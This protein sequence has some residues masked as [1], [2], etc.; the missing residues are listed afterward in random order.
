MSKARLRGKRTRITSRKGVFNP[1]DET[2]VKHTKLGI[3]DLYEEKE[4]EL[5]NIPG[6]SRLERFLALKQN[7]PYL[8]MMLRDIGSIRSCWM[9]LVYYGILIFIG[10]LI[11]AVSIWYAHNHAVTILRCSI[12]IQVQREHA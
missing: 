11:P 4:P 10:S 12:R 3:W 5:A 8:W 7:L 6:S 9:L 1:E 2:K